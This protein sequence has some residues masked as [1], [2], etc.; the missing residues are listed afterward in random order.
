MT[1]QT[2][3]SIFNCSTNHD[4]KMVLVKPTIP[5]AP[6]TI[7]LSPMDQGSLRVYVMQVLC[8]PLSPSSVPEHKKIY[9]ALRIGLAHTLTEIPIIGGCIV[10]EDGDR[11]RVRIDI[12]DG[13]GQQL[14]Y[15]DFTGDSP[16]GYSYAELQEAN[17][18]PSTLDSDKLAAL[19]KFP[20]GSKPAPVMASQANFFSG[21]LMLTVCCHH[22]AID[23]SSIATILKRW[24]RN[25]KAN[26]NAKIRLSKDLVASS[27][28]RTL[29]M[30]GRSEAT[31]TNFPEY[32][33]LKD[34]KPEDL[35]WSPS[36]LS[37][38]KYSIF[39]FS[40]PLLEE[41]KIS[42]SPPSD[43]GEW[44][45]TNDALC[46]FLWHHIT[47]A[48]GIGKQGSGDLEIAEPVHLAMS[49]NG[50]QRLS[51]PAPAD[52][53]GNAVWFCQTT[54]GQNVVASPNLSQIAKAIRASLIKFDSAYLRGV[55]NALDLLPTV[56]GL[57]FTCYDNP[58]RV[59][60][61]SSWADTGLYDLDWELAGRAE[62]IR[63]PRFPA[64]GGIGSGVVYPR[65]N[66]RG[67]EVLLGL[68]E[69]TMERLMA[70]SDFEK[71]AKWRCT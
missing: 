70:D 67:L 7:S 22:S 28:D 23:A 63:F 32:K 54:L 10:P 18:P 11:G 68:E 58:E 33:V 20:D 35:L 31:I 50:R 46:A 1:P 17:F 62:A 9:S 37:T 15:R 59:F 21:G 8:F 4:F 69:E 12:A 55:I 41:L 14:V 16:L 38:K 26:A 51:P 3:R 13:Y 5:A 47:L 34:Q 36:S 65:L 60:F 39:Y 27:T 25:T 43:S 24:A 64:G 6:R 61:L 48:R 56:S 29:L 30:Q 45:S 44:V 66:D 52:Y 53:I 40:K 71:Y 49:I 42:S 57:N 2:P 19:S